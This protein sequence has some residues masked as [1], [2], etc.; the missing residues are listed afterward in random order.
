[1][2]QRLLAPFPGPAAAQEVASAAASSSGSGSPRPYHFSSTSPAAS[3]GRPPLDGSQSPPQGVRFDLT[4]ASALA[5]FV[6]AQLGLGIG[7]VLCESLTF[8]V[9]ASASLPRA[10]L[11]GVSRALGALAF[12]VL[13]PLYG[14]LLDSDPFG[15]GRRASNASATPAAAAGSRDNA[16]ASSAPPNTRKPQ[17]TLAAAA[18]TSD[19]QMLSSNRSSSGA[20]SARS[21][22]T[23]AQY[24]YSSSYENP[25]VR[26]QYAKRSTNAPSPT[27]SSST[28]S[29]DRSARDPH[30][31]QPEEQRE[32]QTESR[33][34]RRPY[35]RERFMVVAVCAAMGF[36]ASVSLVFLYRFTPRPSRE[37]VLR[38]VWRVVRRPRIAFQLGVVLVTGFLFG[39][40]DSL[41]YFWYIQVRR[42]STLRHHH[43][44]PTQLTSNSRCSDRNVPLPYRTLV[45]MF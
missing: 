28:Q 21:R 42:A 32:R 41:L 35:Q 27:S 5:T 6:P 39:S 1:M 26:L 43:H 36:A 37:S 13:S 3:S 34:R 24:S 23:N 20:F 18:H 22:V 11:Y 25:V 8:A 9:A 10:H 38:D 16:S 15:S 44:Q 31:I 33:R 2:P 40:Q 4:Y 12:A 7:R 30:A 14:L 19:M 29:R 17:V 45:N